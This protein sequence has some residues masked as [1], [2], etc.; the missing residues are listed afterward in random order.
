MTWAKYQDVWARGQVVRAG[1]RESAARYDAIRP[2]LDRFK[3]P[4]TVMDL[5]A[6]AGYFC[7]R[8][9]EDYP[10]AVCVAIDGD[11]VMREAVALNKNPRVLWLNRFAT[12]RDMEMLSR[13]AHFD[14]VLALSVFHR[15]GKNA[16]ES[17]EMMHA[18]LNQAG[19]LAFV[20]LPNEKESTPDRLHM[21]RIAAVRSALGKRMYHPTAVAEID[22]LTDRHRAWKRTLYLLERQRYEMLGWYTQAT[23]IKVIATYDRKTCTV[24]HGKSKQDEVRDWVAGMN[25]WAFLVLGGAWP[26]RET[27]VRMLEGVELKEDS[28]ACNLILG[29]GVTPIDG[30]GVDFVENVRE[31]VTHEIR[32]TQEIRR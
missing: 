4:F 10:N 12:P 32:H 1:E 15:I 17:L 7:W 27:I 19:M 6:C 25:L 5:G 2:Y 13:A 29:D 23:T 11:P 28:M 20:D 24:H 30:E 3:R 14:V 18:T 8:I 16:R 21:S 22:V 26:D 31:R 9:A